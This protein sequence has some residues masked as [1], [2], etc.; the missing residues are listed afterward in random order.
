MKDLSTIRDDLLAM[1][2]D[3][4]DEL[5]R[6]EENYG[7]GISDCPLHIKQLLHAT[8]SAES[9]KA[10]TAATSKGVKLPKLDVPTFNGDILNWHTF[11]EQ[12]CISVHDRS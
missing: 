11:W 5:F 3:E 9:T 8:A 7:R 4:S 1:N 10:P 6:H 2:L 12:F